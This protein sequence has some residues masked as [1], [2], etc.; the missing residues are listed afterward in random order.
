M[1]QRDEE[2]TDPTAATSEVELLIGMKLSS[3]N[4]VLITPNGLDN[5][6]MR[7]LEYLIRVVSACSILLCYS[8]LMKLSA[9]DWLLI[10]PN[11]QLK[12]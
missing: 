5:H 8:E 12:L 9:P 7:I 2:T 4:L 1:D 6:N 11:N 3:L 10:T